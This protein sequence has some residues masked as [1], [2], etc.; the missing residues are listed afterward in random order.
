MEL[1]HQLIAREKTMNSSQEL[2]EIWHSLEQQEVRLIELDRRIRALLEVL[3]TQPRLFDSYQATYKL[4]GSS[5]V[6]LEHE[7]AIRVIQEK[8]RQLS[9]TTE[10]G[11]IGASGN[12][13]SAKLDSNRTSR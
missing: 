7:Q 9:E 1:R 5:N 11:G 4:L 2:I 6:I 10:T 3:K 12:P 8:L 13:F